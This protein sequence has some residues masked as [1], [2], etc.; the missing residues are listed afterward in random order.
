MISGKN[1]SD[2]SISAKASL[3][4]YVTPKMKAKVWLKF[5]F[6]VEKS[7]EMNFRR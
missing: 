6:G 5:F 7:W 4:S 1:K 3:K 2:K